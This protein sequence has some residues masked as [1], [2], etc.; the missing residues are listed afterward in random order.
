MLG[1]NIN[2][3]LETKCR[4][5]CFEEE[6]FFK[7]ENKCPNNEI[8]EESLRY[9]KVHFF[10]K[11]YPKKRKIPKIQRIKYKSEEKKGKIREGPKDLSNSITVSLDIYWTPYIHTDFSF[12]P[13]LA[14][15]LR[16]SQFSYFTSK[17]LKWK[18]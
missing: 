8:I 5:Y 15:L 2:F 13:E 3:C 11:N 14:C 1:K 9:C 16:S 7:G 17:P 10:F 4:Y 6:T 18:S 12:N